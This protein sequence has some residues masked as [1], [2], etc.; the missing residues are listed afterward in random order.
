MQNEKTLDDIKNL[1]INHDLCDSCI[2]RLYRDIE[3]GSSNKHKGEIIRKQIKKTNETSPAECWLCEGLLEEITH[4]C[5]LISN[6]LQPYEY[7][8]FLIGS[9]IDENIVQ[10]EQNIWK[11]IDTTNPEPIKMEIN[12]EIGKNLEKNLEKEVHFNNPDIMV[13]IDTAFDV[14]SLQVKP[15]FIYG[16]YKKYDRGIPQ[17]K[18]PCG[19]CQG[20][21]CTRC[22][23]TGRLYPITVEDLVAKNALE[24]TNGTDESFHGCGREDIDARMLGNGRPFI[25]EVKNP[26]IRNIDLNQLEKE[27]NELG[28][29]KIEIASLR[30]STRNEI[31]RIKAAEFIKIYRVT[32]EATQP[33]NKEKLKK[34]AA[35]LRG[36]IIKQFTPTR[37]AHRRANK[38]RE[39]KIYNC[40]IESVEGTIARLAIETESGTYVKELI[41][42]DNQ[43]TKPNLSELLGIPCVVKELD[44]IEIKGE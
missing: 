2:G 35:T 16:R 5:S 24:L 38:V 12:R 37:V 21:G 18:W 26:K 29:D 13:L 43:K 40:D 10:K 19:I 25:L 28:K 15:L 22:N 32:I 20:K 23:N 27:T 7:E 11:S 31:E 1:L 9:K 42:G 14:V 41:S 39:R 4:F 17:T 6:A 36:T 33:F 30:F 8:T 44:V 3:Q 34:A